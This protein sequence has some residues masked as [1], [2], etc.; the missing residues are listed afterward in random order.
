MV[1]QIIVWLAQ[2]R[3][4]QKFHPEFAESAFIPTLLFD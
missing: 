4:A 1:N 2:L 3:S